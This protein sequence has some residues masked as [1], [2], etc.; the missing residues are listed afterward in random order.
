MDKTYIFFKTKSD[1][2]SSNFRPVDKHLVPEIAQAVYYTFYIFLK[3]KIKMKI[4]RNSF[5]LE[6]EKIN[7]KVQRNCAN[8]GKISLSVSFHSDHLKASRSSRNFPT[9]PTCCIFSR[10]CQR[11]H[12]FPR[13]PSFA[14]FL[15]LAPAITFYSV[16]KL[17]KL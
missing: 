17:L 9:L 12:V 15:A 7:F 5:P 1:R 10:A 6:V 3:L 8:T 11:I 2:K 13:F 4:T 14:S 16:P